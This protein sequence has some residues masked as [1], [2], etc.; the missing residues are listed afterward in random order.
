MISY[1]DAGCES[2]LDY[3]KQTILNLFLKYLAI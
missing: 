3:V 1:K 2:E